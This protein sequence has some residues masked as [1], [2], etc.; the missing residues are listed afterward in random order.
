M[1]KVEPSRDCLENNRT[2][3]LARFGWRNTLTRWRFCTPFRGL[4]GDQNGAYS[5]FPDS[6]STLDFS[7]LAARQSAS[8]RF[9]WMPVRLFACRCRRPTRKKSPKPSRAEIAPSRAHERRT[10]H[11]AT[12]TAVGP[13]R[14]GS[15]RYGLAYWGRSASFVAEIGQGVPSRL[16]TTPALKGMGGER[17]NPV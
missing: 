5:E 10:R 3:R 15:R 4:V 14:P 6:L 11:S 17:H 9:P 8:L 7:H 16:E 2:S 12:T 13:G 1:A